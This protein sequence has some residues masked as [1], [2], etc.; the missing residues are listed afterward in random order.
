VRKG[1][2]V[3]AG[4]YGVYAA[5]LFVGVPAADMLDHAEVIRLLAS[6]P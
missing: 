2:G 4:V 6:P 3:L 1:T 5:W